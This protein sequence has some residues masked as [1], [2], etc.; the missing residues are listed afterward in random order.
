MSKEDVESMMIRTFSG[1]ED[2]S[3]PT[4][5]R[6]LVLTHEHET[7]ESG[8]ACDILFKG[9]AQALSSRK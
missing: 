7:S 5:Q 6:V 9:S 2:Y 1:R 8:Q 4:P 3:R